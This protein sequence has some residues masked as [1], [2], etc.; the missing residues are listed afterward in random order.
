M[1]GN[2]LHSNDES[3]D[4]CFKNWP[5]S[6][7]ASK[8]TKIGTTKIPENSTTS[9]DGVITEPSLFALIQLMVGGFQKTVIISFLRLWE[10]GIKKFCKITTSDGKQLPVEL[11]PDKVTMADILDIVA[12]IET[13]LELKEI[14][15]LANQ[16][17]WT[18]C[19]MLKRKHLAFE[20][21]VAAV[22]NQGARQQTTGRRK[23]WFAHQSTSKGT[24]QNHNAKINVSKFLLA[25]NK[26]HK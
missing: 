23:H 18:V 16:M 1:V 10:G 17:E 19:T 20:S 3:H 2:I 21:Y 7:F 25:Y 13:L 24:S 8:R 14:E 11:D 15:F 22:N 9:R 4:L 6:Y 5:I 26:G 12:W